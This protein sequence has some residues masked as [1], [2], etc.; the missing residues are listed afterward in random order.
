V[1]TFFN[2]FYPKNQLGFLGKTSWVIWV[3]PGCLNP[4]ASLSRQSTA[5]VLTTKRWMEKMVIACIAHSTGCHTQSRSN[6]VDKPT[7]SLE[8]RTACR[9]RGFAVEI[10]HAK[11]PVHYI[12]ITYSQRINTANTNT[13]LHLNLYSKTSVTNLAQN[14]S[15]QCTACHSRGFGIEVFHINSR[16][17]N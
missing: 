12:N 13:E 17:Q 15:Q 2:R 16:I 4:E 10:F 3:L 6:E 5:L 9:S 7:C 11:S 1:G 14:S 8:Q